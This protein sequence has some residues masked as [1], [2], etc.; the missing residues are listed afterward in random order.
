MN[1][2]LFAA[3]TACG[4][5]ATPASADMRSVYSSIAARACATTHP[6]G[7]AREHETVIERCHTPYGFT[8]VSTYAGTSM[9]LAILRPGETREPQLGASFGHGDTIEW[10]SRRDGNRFVPVAAIV[11]L[12]F[13]TGKKT[14]Q[15]VLAILRIERDRICPVAF[16]DG[17]TRDA[18]ALARK[19][20][21]DP[22]V[23]CAP[24]GPS[25]IGPATEWAQEARDRSHR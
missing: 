3:A 2:I 1:R 11:R 18:N 8:V 12:L 15:S 22:S 19:T 20:A 7:D 17:S 6:K 24:G 14:R 5:A 23:S 25:I 13:S 21:D 4:L 10:R 9:Q 16:V